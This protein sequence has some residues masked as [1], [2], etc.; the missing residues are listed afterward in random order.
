[1]PEQVTGVALIVPG[2]NPSSTNALPQHQILEPDPTIRAELLEDEMW[3][4][5][6]FWVL[7]RRDVLAK[8]RKILKPAMQ[9]HDQ[10][11][12]A[13]VKQAFDFSFARDEEKTTFE[14]PALIVAGR[15]DF[16]S[17]Y[18]D[19]MDLMHRFPRATLAVLDSAG[20]VL[21]LERPNVFTA[22]V[23]DWLQRLEV[24][25]RE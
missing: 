12:E 21:D 23:R 19:A 22:L 2:G 6:N 10:A 15:Q 3:S 17:G 4:F 5:K 9:I 14:K 20:H 7:Q 16:G 25:W 11:Q 1:M 18:L 24:D 13:R 8:W